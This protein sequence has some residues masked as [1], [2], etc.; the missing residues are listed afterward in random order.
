ME[1]EK[2]NLREKAAAGGI[3]LSETISCQFIKRQQ[4]VKFPD[5]D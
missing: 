5:W 3:W 2:G 4:L 1:A